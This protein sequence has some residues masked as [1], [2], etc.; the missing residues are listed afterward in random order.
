M[1]RATLAVLSLLFAAPALAQPADEPDHVFTEAP[2]DRT[3]GQADAPNT[4]I[5]Y[6]SNMC[7]HCGAW[8]AKDW[9]TVKSDLVEPGALRVVF[10][11]LPTQPMQM[12]LTGFLMAECAPDKAYMSVIED[13]FARQRAILGAKDG[14]E[15]RAQFDAVARGAGLADEA[16]ITACL[17]DPANMEPILRAEQRSVA[18]RI[19][20][21]PGFVFNGRVMKGD[22]DAEAIRGWVE[23][24]STAR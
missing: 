16:A 21:V 9:P 6:A 4:L 17:S 15:I 13:Q 3:L 10:R 5:V 8:F 11:P 2:T 18:G 24:R 23:G 7:P 20:G 1:I 12:S 22:H 19:D 14:T